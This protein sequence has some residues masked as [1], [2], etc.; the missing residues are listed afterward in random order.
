MVI[1]RKS[2]Q[3]QTP[4]VF[5]SA[6]R[7]RH[8]TA[9]NFSLRNRFLTRT[10]MQ[11][12]TK[13]SK[14]DGNKRSLSKK[15]RPFSRKTIDMRTL[16][17]SVNKDLRRYGSDTRAIALTLHLQIEY[18]LDQTLSEMS[19]NSKIVIAQCDTASF[20]KKFK[21]LKSSGIIKEDSDLAVNIHCIQKI[22]NLY[23]HEIVVD[24]I[25]V[26]VERYIRQMKEL[27]GG[28]AA[29]LQPDDYNERF[30]LLGLE[31]M[32]STHELY[33]KRTQGATLDTEK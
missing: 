27:H 19:R 4:S 3:R 2:F 5:D 13:G 11:N 12:R 6:V 33:V 17:D 31:T 7:S 22:R 18:W 14:T 20:G 30:I 28:H 10:R 8:L 32:A 16:L 29:I 23:G 21:F 25:A 15:T 1:L 24:S 26:E 9:R